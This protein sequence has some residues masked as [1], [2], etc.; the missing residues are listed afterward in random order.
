MAAD[1]AEDILTHGM[2]FDQLNDSMDR[3][4]SNQDE[5]LTKTNQ[6]YE[7]NQMLR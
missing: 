2:G 1:E 4:S 7:M 5:Y 3:I 6:L